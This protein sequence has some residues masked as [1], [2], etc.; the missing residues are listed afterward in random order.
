MVFTAI[1]SNCK[2]RKILVEQ[3]YCTVNRMV[4]MKQINPTPYMSFVHVV[5]YSHF[6]RLYITIY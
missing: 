5:D 2:S 6:S 4:E 1:I 3:F